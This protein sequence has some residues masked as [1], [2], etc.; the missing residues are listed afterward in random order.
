M[1]RKDAVSR[2]EEL[3]GQTP[4]EIETPPLDAAPGSEGQGT[5][6]GTD[7]GIPPEALADM[8]IQYTNKFCVEAGLSPLAEVQSFILRMGIVGTAKKYNLSLDIDK[9]PELALI[10]GTV[11]ITLDKVKEYKA[12]HPEKKK[13]EQKPEEQKEPGTTEAAV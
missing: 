3:R 10:G 1:I 13:E 2:L 11:W 5:E 4:P 9:Y 8:V 7:T 12:K 6:P